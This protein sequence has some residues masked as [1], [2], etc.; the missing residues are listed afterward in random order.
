MIQIT[1][2]TDPYCTWCWGSEPIFR[3]LQEA[4]G[5]RLSVRFVMG[6]LVEDS[7]SFADPAN[8][9]GG[10]NWLEPIAAHWSEASA[11]HGMPVEVT[12][13]LKTAFTS[14]WPSNIAYEA[15]KMQ[16]AAAAD[17][18]LRRLREAVA[19]EG[20]DISRRA[21]LSSVALEVGLDIDRFESDFDGQARDEFARDRLECLRRGV[22]GFPAF[23]VRVG[24][25][26]RLLSG[27]RTFGQITHV[28]D[29]LAGHEVERRS[30]HFEDPAVLDF[31]EKYDSAAVREVSE[32]FHVSDDAAKA[33]L[34]RLLAGGSIGLTKSGLLYRA[35][36]VV[37]SDI[38]TGECR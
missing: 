31:V 16:D 17:R 29:M 34:E 5:E 20:E 15:A 7:K 35:L 27:Y 19:T 33:A 2:Y 18:Y 24:D 28:I 14:T 37:S 26:E 9:I 10:R 36:D 30:S 23:L 6:G 22:S 8:G 21:V 4:Y 3:H 11:R 13:F 12:G 32:V 38:H 1:Q 25:R